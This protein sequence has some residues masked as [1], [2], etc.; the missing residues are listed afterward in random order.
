MEIHPALLCIAHSSPRYLKRCSTK[1]SRARP[2]PGQTDGLPLNISEI[3][4]RT[5]NKTNKTWAIHAE[6]PAIPL[7][8]KSAAIIATIKKTIA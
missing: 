5:K 3:I 1:G 2:M 7:K 4:K 6:V 8:P